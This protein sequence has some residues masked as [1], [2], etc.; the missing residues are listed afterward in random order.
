MGAE[1]ASHQHKTGEAVILYIS[2]LWF[3]DKKQEKQIQSI[4]KIPTEIHPATNST[5]HQNVLYQF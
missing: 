5:Y 2:T 3:L 1:Q 4:T